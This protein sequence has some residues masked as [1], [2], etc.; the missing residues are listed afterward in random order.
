MLTPIKEL[1]RGLGGSN[2]Q[3]HWCLRGGDLCCL[4]IYFCYVDELARPRGGHIFVVKSDNL[5]VSKP[6]PD[7]THY[8]WL[9]YDSE[10]GY[11]VQRASDRLDVSKDALDCAHYSWLNHDSECGYG[12]RRASDRFGC[13]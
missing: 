9:N 7:C 11:G 3:D 10:C 1:Q 8:S 2:G 4:R 12:V 5:D 13:E 6:A